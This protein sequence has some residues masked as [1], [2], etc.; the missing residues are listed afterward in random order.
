MN[1]VCLYNVSPGLEKSAEKMSNAKINFP[2]KIQRFGK[3][4]SNLLISAPWPSIFAE[5]YQNLSPAAYG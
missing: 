3:C 1:F 4:L 5:K 2:L